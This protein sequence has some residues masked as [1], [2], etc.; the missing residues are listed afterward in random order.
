MLASR[1]GAVRGPS[2]ICLNGNRGEQGKNHENGTT[3]P[4]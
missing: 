4:G 1:N 3:H 2:K